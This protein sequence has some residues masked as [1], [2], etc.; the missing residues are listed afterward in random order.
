[1]QLLMAQ[2]DNMVYSIAV[3]GAW[4][5]SELGLQTTLVLTSEIWGNYR[6]RFGKIDRVLMA[7]YYILFETSLQCVPQQSTCNPFTNMD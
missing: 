1:M 4:H 7:P 6:E 3:I 2:Y 5:Q